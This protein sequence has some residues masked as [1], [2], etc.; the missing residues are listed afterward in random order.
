MNDEVDALDTAA[1]MQDAP[2]QNGAKPEPNLSMV[3]DIPITLSLE[4]G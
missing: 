1:A 2:V 4:L 3:M